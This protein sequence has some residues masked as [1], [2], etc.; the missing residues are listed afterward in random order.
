MIG[1]VI[2]KYRKEKQM[3]QEEMAD[4]LGV[5]A[6]AVNKWEKGN[7]LPDV[8]LL[9]PIARL[10]GISTDILLSYEEELT[11]QEINRILEEISEKVKSG[12]YDSAFCRA[13]EKIREYPSCEKL[14]LL[15]AQSLDGYRVI[16]GI[17]EGEKYDRKIFEW[18]TRVLKSGDSSMSQA[19]AIGLYQ[20]CMR[21]K[22]YDK[23]QEYL[24]KVR[25]RGS[26]IKQ[27]QADLYRVQGK[28][29]EAYRLCEEIVFSCFSELNGA[30]NGLVSLALEKDDREKAEI[31]VKKQKQ[32]AEILEMGKYM[33]ASPGL[34]YAVYMQDREMVLNILAEVVHSVK[35]IYDFR[36]SKLYS[37]MN[38]SDTESNEMIHILQKA[39]TEDEDI[40]FVREDERYIELM[41]E[42]QDIIEREERKSSQ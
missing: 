39:L 8:S 38:F 40:A 9:A 35:N 3:T 12:D 20:M 6:S 25:Q 32:L 14:I 30:M 34:G 29:E 33:E 19:A 26:M 11:E 10:L 27:M 37:H 18:L 22:E 13:D 31:I 17:S 21:K 41:E 36:R 1:E 5:T 24:N 4:Y 16:Y 2:R 28:K 23:A 7:S 15:A 42:L